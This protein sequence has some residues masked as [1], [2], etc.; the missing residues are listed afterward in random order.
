[1]ET[2]RRALLTASPMLV[3]LFLT[4]LAHGQAIV[5]A[6]TNYY[7]SFD[8]ACQGIGCYFKD[9]VKDLAVDSAGNVIV[10]GYSGDTSVNTRD[11]ATVKYS[12]AGVPLWTNRYKDDTYDM[13]EA[14]AVDSNGNVFVTGYSGGSNKFSTTIKCS[15]AGAPL[16][17]NHYYGPLNGGGAAAMAVDGNGDVIVAENAYGPT[18]FPA[19]AWATIKYS[20]AGVPLWTNRYSEPTGAPWVSGLAVDGSGDVIVAGTTGLPY[21]AS[22]SGAATFSTVK[23]SGAGVPLWTN[24]Y[25]DNQDYASAVA[26]D[27]SGD[28]I[29]TGSSDIGYYRYATIKYS[30]AGVPLWTNYYDNGV[31]KDSTAVA[32]AADSSGN[33]YVTGQSEN[34]LAAYDYVTIKYSSG[35]VPL[36]TNRYDSG[37]DDFASAIAVDG[38]GNAYVT[39]SSCSG[40]F[41]TIAYSDAGVPLWTNRYEG[42]GSPF[43]PGYEWLLRQVRIALDG[44]GN[45]IVAGSS[46]HGGPI[47][48]TTNY[49]YVTIK[50][51]PIRLTIER[52]NGSGFFIHFSGTP[53]STCRLQRAPAL[54]GAWSDI[55]TNTAPLSGLIEYHEISPPPGSGFYRVLQQ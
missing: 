22:A 34:T 32:L 33:V 26:V 21:D 46:D 53:D 6:W 52:D 2:T 28:V 23:Y 3:I 47:N 1:M 48:G 43:P 36:W 8:G 40:S 44:S 7:D 10:T 16:W 13:P 15:S 45:V 30:S 42:G 9:F 49:D 29:V 51:S 31:G 41:A 11:F 54:T 4:P 20:S 39:G 5:P 17:T 35:G 50:Y 38:S 19:D 55:A 37:C 25:R 27:R 14:V 18:F 12:S 24:L